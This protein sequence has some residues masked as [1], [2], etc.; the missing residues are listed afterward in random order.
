MDLHC[1][2]LRSDQPAIRSPVQ[3]ADDS[4][5]HDLSHSRSA[6]GS[7]QLASGHELLTPKQADGLAPGDLVLLGSENRLLKLGISDL[8]TE[9]AR[10]KREHEHSLKQILDNN[11]KLVDRL[12]DQ[13]E[14]ELQQLRSELEACYEAINSYKFGDLKSDCR[15]KPSVS[16][17]T[18]ADLAPVS[19]LRDMLEQLSKNHADLSLDHKQ[20]QEK[21]SKLL[22]SKAAKKK[23][24]D[25]PGPQRLKQRKSSPGKQ[26]RPKPASASNDRKQRRRSMSRK[27]AAVRSASQSRHTVRDTLSVR[28]QSRGGE[29]L[30]EAGLLDSKNQQHSQHLEPSLLMHSSKPA[31][32]GFDLPRRRSDSR[33]AKVVT[34]HEKSRDRLENSHNSSRGNRSGVQAAHHVQFS[35]ELKAKPERKPPKAKTAASEVHLSRSNKHRV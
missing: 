4:H 2:K 19:K 15:K 20:L 13:H 28:K 22:K 31:S 6:A 30:S 33:D 17:Q 18:E 3:Q 12:K 25:A 34:A 16:I 14:R 32:T 21:Y 7:R 1:G 29:R 26:A 24:R 23:Q 5:R 9:L 10:Q 35:S 8:E 27:S 11:K